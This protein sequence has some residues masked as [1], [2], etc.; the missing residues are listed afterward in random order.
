MAFGSEKSKYV[1]KDDAGKNFIVVLAD[2]DII[3]NSGL[4][5]FDPA[6]PP[7]PAISGRLSPKKCRRVYAQGIYTPGG[8]EGSRTIKRAFI[9]QGDSALYTSNSPASIS[10]TGGV[11]LTT[12]GRR[13]EKISF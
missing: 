10:Y 9:C 4:D 1:Y 7:T 11:T 8:A 5:E 2:D 3:T 13:G 6:S 12:T